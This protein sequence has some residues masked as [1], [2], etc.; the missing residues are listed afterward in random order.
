MEYHSRN[1]P[2][3]YSR[4]LLGILD[5]SAV[6]GKQMLLYCLIAIKTTF[7]SYAAA[8]MCENIWF[9]LGEVLGKIRN[10]GETNH[11]HTEFLMV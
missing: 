8:P 10:L 1:I 7:F 9:L 2:R 4:I 5:T 3:F 6:T 11:W